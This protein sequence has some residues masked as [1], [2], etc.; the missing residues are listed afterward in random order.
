[1]VY[2]FEKMAGEIEVIATMSRET[3][4]LSQ[5]QE[6]RIADLNQRARTIGE[7]MVE[8]ARDAGASAEACASSCRS[9]EQISGHIEMV[10]RYAGEI[11][12]GISGFTV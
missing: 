10:V 4:V 1:M 7:L 5:E 3:G 11:H 2:L 9:I 6:N 12:G 8:T